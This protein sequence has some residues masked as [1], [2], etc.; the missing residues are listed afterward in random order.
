MEYFYGALIFIYGL[1]IGSFLNV[2]I[3]RV[4][5]KSFFKSATSYCTECKH[6]LAW[7][8]MIPVLSYI[9]LGGRCRYCKERI[10]IRY[11]LVE[12]LNAVLWLLAYIFFKNAIYDLVLFAI[13]FSVL[14]V[15]A[16][17][18]FDIMEIPNGTVLLI[19]VLGLIRFIL[20]F[21][22]GNTRWYEYLIGAVALSVP[23]LIITL[24]TKGAIG[25]GDIKLSFAV[26]LLLGWKLVLIGGFFG[27]VIAGI[28]GLIMMND[29]ENNK[30]MP[31]GPCLCIGWTIAVFCGNKIIELLFTI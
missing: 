11:P 19:I 16:G 1:V 15:V 18:D 31:L 5:R 8:D 2:V 13:L 28:I 3:Y 12:L 14:I 30:V 26:G 29:K 9:F 22:M 10:S 24:I 20:S 23:L 21:F 4:P 6:K 27:I 7:Y 17:I 25:L